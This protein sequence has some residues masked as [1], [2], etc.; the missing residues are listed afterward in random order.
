MFQ[1]PSLLYLFQYKSSVQMDQCLGFSGI[2]WWC[3]CSCN[4]NPVKSKWMLKYGIFAQFTT[5]GFKRRRL[6]SICYIKDN[7]HDL[8]HLD[9]WGETP[10]A[11]LLWGEFEEEVF[12]EPESQKFYNDNKHVVLIETEQLSLYCN[13]FNASASL[14]VNQSRATFIGFKATAFSPPRSRTDGSNN[15]Q[16]CVRTSLKLVKQFVFPTENNHY[17]LKIP[18]ASADVRPRQNNEDNADGRND[19]R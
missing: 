6:S 7:L 19:G 8:F 15:L 16:H 9:T 13:M 11:V 12:K 4:S 18:F 10:K 5:K 17:L 3:G 2:Q 1:S 14:H